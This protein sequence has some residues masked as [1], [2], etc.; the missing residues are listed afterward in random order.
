MANLIF[1]NSTKVENN[2]K[3]FLIRTLGAD[4][5]ISQDEFEKAVLDGNVF[6]KAN[7]PVY[8][9]DLAKLV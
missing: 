5:W 1:Q 3:Q 6:Y 8:P 7:K 9:A 4:F 2:T